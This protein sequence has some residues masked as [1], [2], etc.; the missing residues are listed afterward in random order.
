MPAPRRALL[1]LLCLLATPALVGA[2]AAPPAGAAEQDAAAKEAAQL[3]AAA[4]YFAGREKGIADPAADLLWRAA[5]AAFD[6]G[7]H[8]QGLELAAEVLEW[9]PE[10]RA[11]REHLG[12]VR[13]KGAWVEDPGRTAEVARENTR[14]PAETD[15]EWRERYAGWARRYRDA[16]RSGIAERWLK[17]ADDCRR[18]GH[19][20]QVERAL[21][22][23][24]VQEPESAEAA[25]ALGLVTLDGV[26][27]PERHAEAFRAVRACEPGARVEG[28]AKDLGVTLASVQSAHVRVLETAPVEDLEHCARVA[29]AAR[30]LTLEIIGRAPS[31]DVFGGRRFHVLW[32]D[33]DVWPAWAAARASES[34]SKDEIL[35]R[36]SYSHYRWPWVSYKR[37]AGTAPRAS[38]DRAAHSTA[39]AVLRK[40]FETERADWVDEA[41]A[42][43]VARTVVPRANARCA[44]K[45][46]RRYAGQSLRTRFADAE[47]WPSLVRETVA[48]GDDIP[49]RTILPRAVTEF[50][51]E[52]SAKAWSVLTWLRR[53]DPAALAAYIADA[54][55]DADHPALL[56]L[57]FGLT[58]E[59]IDEAWR[60]W[61]LRAY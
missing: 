10:H 11:A 51:L 9:D 14:K 48:A 4:R 38:A 61:V 57:R 23:V 13:R 30:I 32:V 8:E 44:P 50:D 1:G 59:Q 33:A 60:A 24:R 25:A 3:E 53:R 35:G 6:E 42:F 49:L 54:A 17:L 55:V 20:E 58:P 16:A 39:H 18:K 56:E 27:V 45:P 2:P 12:F 52:D 26:W 46:S 7:F 15:D 5:K 40:A 43:D 29:E 36:A 22:R 47:L 31:D 37:R 21:L 28:W 41:I 19:G 34:L